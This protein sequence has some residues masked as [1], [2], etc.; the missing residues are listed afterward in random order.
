MLDLILVPWD[1]IRCAIFGWDL[2]NN[3]LGNIVKNYDDDDDS[4]Q[5]QVVK[6]D[7]VKVFHIFHFHT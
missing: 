3:Q 7:V 4:E 5:F 1:S 6:P 2:Y